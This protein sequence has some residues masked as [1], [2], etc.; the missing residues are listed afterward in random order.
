MKKQ[1]SCEIATDLQEQFS[2]DFIEWLSSIGI[3][4]VLKVP[5]RK[6]GLTSSGKANNCHD[7]VFQL[8]STFGGRHKHGFLLREF[9]SDRLQQQVIK[10][11]L[12][13]EDVEVDSFLGGLCYHSV[14]LTPE[15][16]LVCVTT[17]HD[18]TFVG[19]HEDDYDYFFLLDND[20][21]EESCY[22]DASWEKFKYKTFSHVVTKQVV[23]GGDELDAIPHDEPLSSYKN[24]FRENEITNT[25]RKN[26]ASVLALKVRVREL[27][28]E[29]TD[30]TFSKKSILT[31]RRF[32][33]IIKIP[34]HIRLRKEYTTTVYSNRKQKRKVYKVRD[35]QTL[36]LSA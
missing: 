33:D 18:K 28:N 29:D 9:P 31:K 24:L 4:K 5:K 22:D 19:G 30:G 10:H 15:N 11:P 12:T 35:K 14:W 26:N 20:F 8:V 7:N 27:H 34:K 23:G 6:K 13:H 1:Y 36:R 21:Q 2:V 25:F 17:S 32:E 3:K 16:K